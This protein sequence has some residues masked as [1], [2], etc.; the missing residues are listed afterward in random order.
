LGKVK[1]NSFGIPEPN[2]IAAIM[3]PEGEEF[4]PPREIGEVVIKGPALMKGYWNKPNQ[5]REVFVDIDG[6]KWFKTGDL[7]SMDEEGYF[8][9]YDRKKDMIKY[10]GHSVFAR[11]IEEVLSSHPKIKEAGVIGVPDPSVGEKIKA[12]VVPEVDARGKL[13]EEE[14]LRH[15]KDRLADY[16]VPKIIEFVG[17]IPKTDVGRVSRRE[18]RE[19]E[20]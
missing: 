5:T 10:R 16:K 17:E 2:I 3:D 15:C 8:Y 9:F 13:F 1:L 19:V 7:A 20:S 12:Y 11:E 4:L 14:V 18:L 6:E